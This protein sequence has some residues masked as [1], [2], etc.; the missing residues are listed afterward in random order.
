MGH[1]KD[2]D[3][4]RLQALRAVRVLAEQRLLAEC[5]S[6]AVTEGIVVEATS[7]Y[8]GR[9]PDTPP[10]TGERKQ[11]W[12]WSYRCRIENQRCGLTNTS[13]HPPFQGSRAS[14]TCMPSDQ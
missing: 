7:S 5:S 1:R 2:L 6:R 11:R 8:L 4:F 9:V 3:C 12:L 13:S 14:V 10:P